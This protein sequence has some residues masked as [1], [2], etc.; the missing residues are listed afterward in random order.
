MNEGDFLLAVN[1]KPLDPTKDVGA[2][3]EGLAN[4][5]VSI[6]VNDKPTLAG[7]R[8]VLVKP[9]A[10][11]A[12]LR[13]LAWIEANR[14]RVEQATHGRV[15]Y[16]FVP[17][18]GVD[19]QTELV[20]QYRAQT[21]KDGMIIDER[22]NA[23]GQI[24]DRFVELLDRP[25]KSYWKTRDGIE[26]QTPPVSNPGPKAMLINGWSGSGGDAFPF[27]FK[28]AGLG[29]LIGRRTWGGLIGI[30]GTPSLMDG[31]SRYCADVRGLRHRRQVGRR[32]P[33]RGAG[34]R[35]RRRSNSAVEGCRSAAGAGDQGSNDG[36]REA[37]EASGCAGLH[38]THCSVT[39]GK[40]WEDSGGADDRAGG[41]CL[42]PHFRRGGVPG[43]MEGNDRARQVGRISSCCRRT[44][45]IWRRR[46]SSWAPRHC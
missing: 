19:G 29:P 23:G 39:S 14:M 1:G 26:Q 25:I 6:T 18:T 21:N 42:Y 37:A 20:R 15:G 38:E 28:Q 10:D 31:G 3:F 12:R 7:A 30:S 45:S 32:R 17:N 35:R 22:F 9:L 44:S 4:T 43:G 24:P 27:Y 5:V 33:R 8:T 46:R 2:S 11:E 40:R 34:H 36:G 16:V 41:D 13:N